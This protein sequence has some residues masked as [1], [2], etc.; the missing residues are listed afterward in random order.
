MDRIDTTNHHFETDLF[1]VVRLH[2]PPFHTFRAAVAAIII[3]SF[4]VVIVVAVAISFVLFLAARCRWFALVVWVEALA[5]QHPD[6]SF[7]Y[8]HT[9]WVIQWT[10]IH[11]Q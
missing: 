2:F 11:P 4:V 6:R 7:Q 3:T 1:A 8:S 10:E 9:A 5:L